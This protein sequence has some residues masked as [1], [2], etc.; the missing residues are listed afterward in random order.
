[1]TF[2]FAAGAVLA[3]TLTA[4]A[5]SAMAQD[6]AQPVLITIQGPCVLALNGR[7]LQCAG[8]AYMAFPATHRI[9]FTALTEQAGWA[10]SGDQDQN[11]DGHYTLA[12]DSVVNPRAGRVQAQ[13]QCA[14]VVAEDGRTVDSIECQAR[15]PAGVMMLKAS[16]KAQTGAD[17]DD[18]DDDDGP[19]SLQG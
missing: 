7:P 16:G 9:D 19:D 12:V 14:M 5:P 6:D 1:M 2:R 10:F 4:A 18:D 8:V 17:D 13:G 3:L 15:T 11:D